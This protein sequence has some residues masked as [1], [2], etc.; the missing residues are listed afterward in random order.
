MIYFQWSCAKPRSLGSLA[1]INWVTNWGGARK[2]RLLVKYKSIDL[3]D[4]DPSALLLGVAAVVTGVV[5][6]LASVHESGVHPLV[7]QGLLPQGH[8]KW[9]MH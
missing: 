1:T 8:L 9:N 2:K 6:G 7:V 5:V 3:L 4:S